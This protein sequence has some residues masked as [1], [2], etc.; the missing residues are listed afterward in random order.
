VDR[1]NVPSLDE[2]SEARASDDTDDASAA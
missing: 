1:I 2:S